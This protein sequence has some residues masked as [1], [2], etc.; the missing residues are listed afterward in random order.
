VRYDALDA[1]QQLPPP[2]H[3]EGPAMRI[4]RIL[5]PVDFSAHAQAALDYSIE[6]GRPF[7]AEISVLHVVEPIYYAVPDFTGGTAASMVSLLEEQRRAA[8]AG[9]I[10]P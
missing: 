9:R 3:P 5:V 1:A 2:A 4:K 10:R 6:F 7:K 8:R